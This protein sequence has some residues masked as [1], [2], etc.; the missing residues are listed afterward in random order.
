MDLTA[1]QIGKVRLPFYMLPDH[2]DHKNPELGEIFEAA[3]P[4]VAKI[5]VDFDPGHPV[6]GNFKEYIKSVEAAERRRGVS[7]WMRTFGLAP[8]PE[9]EAV[10]SSPLTSLLDYGFSRISWSQNARTGFGCRALAVMFG[11]TPLRKGT[12]GE[13][14]AQMIRFNKAHTIYDPEFRPPTFRREDPSIFTPTTA[15]PVILALKR[16]GSEDIEGEKSARK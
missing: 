15:I 7:D 10:L 14:T 1:K 13:V 12:T 9:M 8:T 2:P 16:K 11:A 4:Q 5:L 3:I 6:I